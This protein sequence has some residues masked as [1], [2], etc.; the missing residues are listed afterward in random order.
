MI[1]FTNNIIYNFDKIYLSTKKTEKLFFNKSL[2]SPKFYECLKLYQT[3]SIKVE[4]PSQSF[5][6]IIDLLIKIKNN[7]L[8][9]IEIGVVFTSFSQKCSDKFLLSESISYHKID[10]SIRNIP[11]EAFKGCK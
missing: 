7:T 10:S 9:H 8:H 11:A 1:F 6:S 5:K 4:Y 2:K 3:I